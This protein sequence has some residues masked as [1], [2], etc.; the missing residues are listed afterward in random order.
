[1]YAHLDFQY[2]CAYETFLE[3]TTKK[4]FQYIEFPLSTQYVEITRHEY[5]G[6]DSS[7]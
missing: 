4:D 5:A 3:F 6:T 1:M 7:K 2:T